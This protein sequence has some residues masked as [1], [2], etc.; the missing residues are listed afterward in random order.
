MIRRATS[1]HGMPPARGKARSVRVAGPLLMLILA[2]L[3]L[4]GCA[5]CPPGPTRTEILE[6]DRPVWLP[7]PQRYILP[8]DIPALPADPTNEDLERDGSQL[9]DLLDQAQADRA[10]LRDLNRQR[11]RGDD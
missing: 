11:G 9:E 7:I 5:S 1:L 6:V 8:L 10:S 2:G 3:V 4:A